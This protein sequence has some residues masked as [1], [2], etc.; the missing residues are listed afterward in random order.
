MKTFRNPQ[1]V[2]PPIAGYTHQIEI[3][4]HERLL[5]L[6]GQVGRTEEGTVPEDPI[7]QLDL[8]CENLYRNLQAAGMDFSDVVKLTFYLA[9]EMDA[10]KR[11]DVISSRLKDHKPCM[12]LV[13]V[14]ALANPI[15]KVELDA[16]A[17]KG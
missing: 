17:S 6:S 7:A 14:T 1:N 9:G 8:A 13:Y 3:K 5:V 12:T 10:G 15:Y 2:H 16:W 11:R 4:G